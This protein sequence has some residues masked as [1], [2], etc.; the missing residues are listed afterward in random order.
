LQERAAPWEW[1]AYVKLRAAAGDLSLGTKVESEARAIIHD[2]ARSADALLLRTETRRVRERLEHEK[3]RRRRRSGLEIKYD[4]GGMLDAYFATRYLQLR[5]DVRDE[6]DNR[7]TPAIL[8]RLRLAGSLNEEDYAALNNGYATLRSLDHYLRLIIGRST[9][10]PAADHP[11][12]R[13]IAISMN[14]TSP[15]ALITDLTAHMANIR[16]A[17]DRITEEGKRGN[18]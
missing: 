14:Y 15:D 12:L 11:A 7:S 3:T 10:L 2:A 9:R 4:A 1:L 17:Y 16:A 6:G 5:D 13:D 18:G 8:E